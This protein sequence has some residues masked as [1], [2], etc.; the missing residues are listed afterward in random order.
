MGQI[1]W[2]I[3]TFAALAAT[4]GAKGQEK[5]HPKFQEASAFGSMH[6]V[7]ATVRAIPIFRVNKDAKFA[8]H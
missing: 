2:G 6:V 5:R 4:I 7:A 8:F 3:E 1:L